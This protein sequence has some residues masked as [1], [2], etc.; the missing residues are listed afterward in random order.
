[1]ALRAHRILEIQ[2]AK[3]IFPPFAQHDFGF[4][5]E[6]GGFRFDLPL[7]MAGVG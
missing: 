6:P 3:I 4:R 2:Q 1:M 7:Q 5:S